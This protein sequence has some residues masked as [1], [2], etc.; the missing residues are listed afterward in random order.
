MSATIKDKINMVIK[1]SEK[2]VMRQLGI[3]GAKIKSGDIFSFFSGIY[4][5]QP[6]NERLRVIYDPKSV[7]VLIKFALL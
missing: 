3:Q 4:N 7:V 5:I 1:D 6:L 2:I